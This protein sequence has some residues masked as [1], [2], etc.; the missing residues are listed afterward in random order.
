MKIKELFKFKKNDID[1]LPED[2]SEP[3][4]KNYFKLLWRKFPKLMTLNL[5]MLFQ[6]IPIIVVAF[7]YFWSPT[8]PSQTSALYPV[9][10]GTYTAST[11]SM[12]ALGLALEGW[13]YG[14]PVFSTPVIVAIVI[15]AL[16][17]ILTFGWQ[18][19]GATYVLREMATGN[20]VFIWSDFFYAVKRNLK[21]GFLFG[22]LD[23]IILFVLAYDFIYFYKSPSTF[24]GDFMFFVIFAI[25]IIYTVMRF[26]IYLMMVTFDLSIYKLLKNALIFSVLGIK[27]N[28]MAVIGVILFAL[29]NV[30]L[31]MLLMPVGFVLPLIIPL[32]YFPALAA[33]TTTYAAYPNIKKYMIDPYENNSEE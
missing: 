10:F 21:Q 16:F 4:L 13:Q 33:F 30:L 1:A 27:R 5:M 22:I 15:A 3:S 20:P 31:I 14:L 11:S 9:L 8:T 17:F 28:I 24:G 19:V 26:Y 25:A 23:A 6:V 7:A 12:A 32:F 18:N 2:L 29:V